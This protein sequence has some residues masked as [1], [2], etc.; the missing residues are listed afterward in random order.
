MTVVGVKPVDLFAPSCSWKVWRV[1]VNNFMALKIVVLKKTYA[2][3]TNERD[4]LAA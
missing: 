3:G 2:V 1:A 4:P